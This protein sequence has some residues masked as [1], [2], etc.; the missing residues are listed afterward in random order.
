MVESN[1][2]EKNHVNSPDDQHFGDQ[3]EF[4]LV[5]AYGHMNVIDWRIPLFSDEE[6][7]NSKMLL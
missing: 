5:A 4:S 3:A 6:K 1:F 7:K 2:R